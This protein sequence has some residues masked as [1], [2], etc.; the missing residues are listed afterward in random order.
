MKKLFFFIVFLLVFG[1]SASFS[2]EIIPILPEP[3]SPP[4]EMKIKPPNQTLP[5]G[6]LF[7]EP[8]SQEIYKNPKHPY[9]QGLLESIPT[10]KGGPRS[11]ARPAS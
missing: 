9:T 6:N 11:A 4:F 10:L 3:P 1:M 5:T 8:Q 7:R 2:Q